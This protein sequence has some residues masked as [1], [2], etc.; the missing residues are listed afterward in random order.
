MSGETPGHSEADHTAIALPNCTVGDRFQFAAG[1]AADDQDAR[2]GGNASLKVKTNEC[3][4]KT[5]G[6]FNGYITDQSRVVGVIHQPIYE[7]PAGKIQ[8]GSH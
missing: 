5:A 6:T 7:S 2:R 1:S 4:D 3:D 8:L